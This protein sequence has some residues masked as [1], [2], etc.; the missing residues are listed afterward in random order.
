MT[1]MS[2]DDFGRCCVATPAVLADAM[3][4]VLG[5]D[6]QLRWLEPCV[7]EGAIV[8]AIARAGVGPIRIRG[9]DLDHRAGSA[10]GLAKVLRR[11]EYLTWAQSTPERFDRIV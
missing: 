9:L 5:D 1:E 7:G 10:D 2:L 8:R 11:T 6:R 3:V 4:G